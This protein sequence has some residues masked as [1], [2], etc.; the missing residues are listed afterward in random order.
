MGV[1]GR[2]MLGL[3]MQGHAMACPYGTVTNGNR[4]ET[5]F[6]FTDSMV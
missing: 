5:P 1:F 6:S 2:A 4:G 3:A